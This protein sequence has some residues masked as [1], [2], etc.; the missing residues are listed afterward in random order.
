LPPQL[1]VEWERAEV[2]REIF[3]QSTVLR[4]ESDHRWSETQEE[5]EAPPGVGQTGEMAVV[6]MST[7]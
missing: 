4:R 7:R 5:W 6:S 2:E 3:V 1:E